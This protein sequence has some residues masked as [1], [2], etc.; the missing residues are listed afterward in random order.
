MTDK[1][2]VSE[3]LRHHLE[4]LIE[5]IGEMAD[6]AVHPDTT[7]KRL[8]H[9]QT[10][11]DALA[12]LA[13][14]A[15]PVAWTTETDL[16]FIKCGEGGNIFPNNVLS[17]IPLYAATPAPS[18]VIEERNAIVALIDETIG[19]LPLPEMAAERNA[20]L[21]TKHAILA[22]PAPVAEGW[23][24]VG[25]R[26]PED[27]QDVLVAHYMIE[28]N[29]SYDVAAYLGGRWIFPWDR[30]NANPDPFSVTHWQPIKAPLPAA[31]VR[32]EG[33]PTVRR[34][35]VPDSEV[36]ENSRGEEA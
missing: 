25:E 23:I 12:A 4:A 9:Q 14:E 35:E 3:K 2:A 22:R 30:A 36:G 6:E 7:D 24:P 16:A 32:K 33:E 10:A 8:R 13:P 17:T 18:A 11:K 31:P 27:G 28:P 1:C 29:H 20:L 15:Q 26:L 21:L 19:D 5:W 34:V